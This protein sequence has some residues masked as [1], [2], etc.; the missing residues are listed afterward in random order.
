MVGSPAIGSAQWTLDGRVLTE[1]ELDA[2]EIEVQGKAPCDEKCWRAVEK[3]CVCRCGGLNHGRAWRNNAS[4]DV[5]G[6]ESGPIVSRDIARGKRELILLAR[7]EVVAA[8]DS[9]LGGWKT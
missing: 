6:S 5:F 1:E 2:M 3:R 8:Y 9:L 7:K 4:L